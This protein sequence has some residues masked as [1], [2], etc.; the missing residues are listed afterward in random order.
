MVGSMVGCA[1]ASEAYATAV[2][3]G[4]KGADILADKAQ[5]LADKAVETAKVE[6]PNR[7]VVV[8]DS[9]NVFAAENNLPIRV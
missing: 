4:G 5:K 2:E 9:I 3:Y 1:V 8:K 7:V 6:F